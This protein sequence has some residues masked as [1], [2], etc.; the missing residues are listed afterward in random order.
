[1]LIESKDNKIIKYI[2]KLQDVKYSIIENKTLVESPK[3]IIDLINNGIE[4]DYILISSDIKDKYL[5]YGFDKYKIIEITPK[6]AKLVSN[7]ETT[8]GVFAVVSI[9]KNKKLNSNYLVLDNLQDPSNLGAIL[10]SAV[11]FNFKNVILINSCYPYSMKV[12]R[13]SMGNNFKCNLIKMQIEELFKF[14]KEDNIH[15]ISC[16]IN[17]NDIKNSRPTKNNFAIIIGNEGR[18]ISKELKDASNEIIKIPMDVTVESLNASVSA[19]IIMYHYNN[20]IKEGK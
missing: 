15:L 9:P 10:R 7:T 8:T 11:A 4:I 18:G 6:L 5:D 13:S 14:I 2:I 12:S 1:M 20:L 3:L 19:G 17:G 16:D